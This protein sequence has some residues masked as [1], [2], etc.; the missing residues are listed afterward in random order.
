VVFRRWMGANRRWAAS[1]IIGAMVVIVVLVYVGS[2][3][4]FNSTSGDSELLGIS[5][6]LPV[7]PKT[8][9]HKVMVFS[10]MHYQRSYK[11]QDV[12]RIMPA[13]DSVA[14]VAMGSPDEVTQAGMIRQEIHYYSLEMHSG[15]TV[16]DRVVRSY[17][18][19]RTADLFRVNCV[20]CHGASMTGDGPIAAL[21]KERGLGPVPAD[22]T[23]E[24]TQKKATEGEVFAFITMGGR[25][26][27]TM[28]QAGHESRSPMPP[29]RWLLSEDDRWALV[30]YV[31]GR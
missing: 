18:A 15:L 22:L 19:G 30:Q 28:V 5:F 23:S 9:S 27:M 17:D 3:F 12:P 6:K 8:G 4:S 2:Q 25:Q 29:F 16:P 1:A 7:F 21:M 11:V 13:S 24:S 31:L 10:E 20:M 26:G 14:F